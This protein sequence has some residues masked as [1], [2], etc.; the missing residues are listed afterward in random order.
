MLDGAAVAEYVAAALE[1]F[2]TS[3]TTQLAPGAAPFGEACVCPRSCCTV[4]C[5]LSNFRHADTFSSGAY[6]GL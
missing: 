3:S 4:A 6:A 1:P 5:M 2:L